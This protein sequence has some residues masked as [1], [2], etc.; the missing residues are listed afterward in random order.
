MISYNKLNKKMETN[1]N[2]YNPD[3]VYLYLVEKINENINNV[4]NIDNF[5]IL[6]ELIQI[7]NDI[8]EFKLWF[9]SDKNIHIKEGFTNWIN[10]IG[11]NSIIEKINEEKTLMKMIVKPFI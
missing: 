6:L 2:I 11:E 8:N 7:K 10:R 1:T 4:V 5:N 3:A 9:N